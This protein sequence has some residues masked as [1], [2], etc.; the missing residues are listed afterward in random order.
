MEIIKILPHHLISYFEAF[1]LNRDPRKDDE[2]Y[3]DEKFKTFGENSIF[4]VINNPDQLVQIVS[5][6]DDFCRM[7]PRNQRGQNYVQ[8]DDTCQGYEDGAP[9]S[10]D[11]LVASYLGIA[12]LT[13]KDPLTSKELFAK[14]KVIFKTILTEKP[15]SNSKK[16]SAREFFHVSP[17]ELMLLSENNPNLKIN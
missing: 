13:D 17:M 1:Y 8:K 3:G 16:I 5:K 9:V 10:Q 12:E 11:P 15:D 2:W 14:L 4:S 7:C 6:Y